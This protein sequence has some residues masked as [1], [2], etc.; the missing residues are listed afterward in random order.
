M[1]KTTV[2]LFDPT[3]TIKK[4][5]PFFYVFNIKDPSAHTGRILYTKT[6]ET[7]DRDFAGKKIVED[8]MNTEIKKLNIVVN[9]VDEK[10]Q[11]VF[12]NAYNKVH[13]IDLIDNGTNTLNELPKIIDDFK[14]FYDRDF[15]DSIDVNIE[16]VELDLDNHKFIS[17]NAYTKEITEIPIKSEEHLDSIIQEKKQKLGQGLFI[18]N[19]TEYKISLIAT[20]MDNGEYTA[21][22]FL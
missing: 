13:N 18:K 11:F 19:L 7:D 5:I 17:T 9:I 14:R 4:F 3:F 22:D 20:H 2:T 8:F 6:Y 1:N 12:K 16:F 15:I 10:I 21:D